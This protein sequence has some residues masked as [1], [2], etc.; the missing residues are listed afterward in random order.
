MRYATGEAS[1]KNEIQ[2]TPEQ[3]RVKN[4]KNRLIA[5]AEAK[6]AG[7]TPEQLE[8]DAKAREKEARV[9]AEEAKKNKNNRK[10]NPLPEEEDKVPDSRTLEERRKAKADKYQKMLER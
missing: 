6:K 7:R 9:R 2:R 4:E 5:E 1:E 3:Q 10:T 8:K